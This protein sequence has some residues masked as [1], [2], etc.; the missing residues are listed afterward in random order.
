MSDWI[1]LATTDRDLAQALT[2]LLG[3]VGLDLRLAEDG[4]S[5]SALLRAV[6]PPA[7]LVLDLGIRDPAGL[8]LCRRVRRDRDL[9]DLPIVAISDSADEVDRVVA[10]EIGVDD[11]VLSPPSVREL[12]LRVRAVLRRS[13]PARDPSVPSERPAEVVVDPM[14]NRVWVGAQEVAFTATEYR[15]LLTFLRAGNRVVSRA[16]LVEAVWDADAD[17]TE[18]TVDSHVRRIRRKLGTAR[19]HLQTLRGVGYRYVL[20]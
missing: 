17:V 5:A 14:W 11:Y 19:H 4:V 1:L 3:D 7:A 20:A 16:E 10:F 13:R 8:D 6:P 18:R 12:A 2:R 15:I 9:G